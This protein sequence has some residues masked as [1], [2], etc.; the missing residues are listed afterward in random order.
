MS[1][2]KQEQ[3]EQ[4]IEKIH[5]E[6][7]GFVYSNVFQNVKID[8]PKHNGESTIWSNLKSKLF[9]VP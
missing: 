7:K 9:F 8:K 3:V 2:Q 4:V 5:K 6:N 1:R